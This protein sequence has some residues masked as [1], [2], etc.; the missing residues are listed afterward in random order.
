M[1][2]DATC[3]DGT[4]D[5]CS[6]THR[7]F[8]VF[9][10]HADLK[11]SIQDSLFDVRRPVLGFDLNDPLAC[12]LDGSLFFFFEVGW[13]TELVEQPLVFLSER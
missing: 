1:L 6:V 7:H 9:L 2:G 10:P 4:V 11:F 5:R 13:A 3:C 8:D 12:P